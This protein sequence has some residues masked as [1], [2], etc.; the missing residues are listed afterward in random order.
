M[1]DPLTP[2]R[3]AQARKDLEEAVVNGRR[4]M[5]QVD[6]KALKALLD[7]AA[8]TELAEKER[9]ETNASL[10]LLHDWFQ[11]Q[12]IHTKAEYWGR[13]VCRMAVELLDE[14]T[15]ER[16]EWKARAEGIALVYDAL[17]ASDQELQ[18]RLRECESTRD[19]SRVTGDEWKLRAETAEAKVVFSKL[20]I[21]VL[22]T[23]IN[24]L[25]VSLA[26]ILTPSDIRHFEAF[27]EDALAM[28]RKA[29]ETK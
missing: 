14:R 16:D 28:G 21:E 17:M 27:F 11:D 2:E 25:L 23:K 4:R 22:S 5:D 20:T 29:T 10:K 24:Q 8:G 6:V 9:D 12:D 3:R 18:Q 7:M 26:L 1:P 13:D 19:R 15:K